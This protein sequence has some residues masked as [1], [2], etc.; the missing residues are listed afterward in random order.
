MQ[1]IA[2]TACLVGSCTSR[3]GHVASPQQQC[4]QPAGGGSS[5]RRRR[6]PRQQCLW[7]QAAQQ[8]NAPSTSGSSN[9]GSGGDFFQQGRE[10]EE[11]QRLFNNIAPVYDQLNDQLSFGLHRVWKRMAVKWSG[12]RTGQRALDV[13]CGS[14]DLA[15]RLAEAVG[16]S[17]SVVGLDFSANMLADAERRQLERQKQLGPAYNM[18]WVQVRSNQAAPAAVAFWQPPFI[19]AHSS[20]QVAAPCHHHRWDAQG[21][22][23]P[24]LSAAVWC[25]NLL[26]PGCGAAGRCL[27]AAV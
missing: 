2:P 22:D 25:C 24:A 20:L 21:S 18:Q 10:G 4:W 9:N 13:C 19:A 26:A 16:P 5:G 7:V 27:E 14:G 1:A 8:A 17:G 3:A 6:S 23:A 11:R 12:A 15:F